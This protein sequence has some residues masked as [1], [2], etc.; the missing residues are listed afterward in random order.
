[1]KVKVDYSMFTEQEIE[2]V[3]GDF[4]GQIDKENPK[5]TINKL[6]YFNIE[7]G[8]DEVVTIECSDIFLAYRLKV[9]IKEMKKKG[10]L[11]PYRTEW[12]RISDPEKIATIQEQESF[13]EL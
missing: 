7:T 4:M 8:Q 12:Q 5:Y 6:Y 3:K 10:Y 13:V 9:A 1:M 11:L 2:F